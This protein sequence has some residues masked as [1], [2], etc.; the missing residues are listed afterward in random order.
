MTGAVFTLEESGEMIAEAERF[1]AEARRLVA[2][3]DAESQTS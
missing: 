1:L 2:G 3:D